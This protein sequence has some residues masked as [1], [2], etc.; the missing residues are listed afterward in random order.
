M[1]LI[2][3]IFILNK[4]LLNSSISLIVEYFKEKFIIFFH[5]HTKKNN[6]SLAQVVHHLIVTARNVNFRDNA[7]CQ[8]IH[9][10]T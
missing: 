2:K 3:F 5:L 10:F 6:Y 7:R 9:Q 4:S 8:T 1:S